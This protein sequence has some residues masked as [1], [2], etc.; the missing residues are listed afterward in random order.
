[1]PKFINPE[2]APA[3]VG[4]YSTAVSTE[5]GFLFLSGQISLDPAT[6]IVSG[7]SSALQAEIILNNIRN[8]VT[9]CGFNITDIIKVVIYLT[10]IAAFSD[11]NNIY[12]A[13]FGN[14]KPVRTTVEVTALPKGALV[15]M[16]VTCFRNI[17]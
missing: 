17:K 7:N 3:A 8:I 16:E 6:G 10:D 12:T 14:H 1:M 11:L 9:A 5:N 4:P 2:N 15:E 13:F